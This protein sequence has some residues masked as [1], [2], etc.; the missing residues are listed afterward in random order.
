MG[1]SIETCLRTSLQLHGIVH[2]EELNA[3]RVKI[4]D[5]FL[6]QRGL[7]YV[8]IGNGFMDNR[9]L[10][11]HQILFSLIDPDIH[12]ARYSHSSRSTVVCNKDAIAASWNPLSVAFFTI[13][14]ASSAQ[15]KITNINS[16]KT[17]RTITVPTS[18][19]QNGK[20]M[21]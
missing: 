15:V 18:S 12:Q 7:M 2:E 14:P 3:P 4:R 19:N 1:R 6:G 10:Y 16:L 21:I 5:Y 20:L 9:L 17:K 11:V 13:V 8:V